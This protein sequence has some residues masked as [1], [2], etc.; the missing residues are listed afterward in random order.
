[1]LFD[2]LDYL[3][4]TGIEGGED[5][6]I[7]EV[8]DTVV[9][10]TETDVVNEPQVEQEVNEEQP[11][12]E[13]EIDGEKYT[14]DQIKEWKLGNMRQSDYSRKTQEVS[15]MRKEAEEAIEVYNY[16]KSNPQLVNALLQ[17]EDINKNDADFVK[18]KTDPTIKEIQDLKQKYYMIEI[19]KELAD[20]TSKDKDVNDVELL[21]IANQQNCDVKTAYTIWKG[22]N[23]DK[24]IEKKIKET[25]S[26]L[27]KEIQSNRGVTKTLITGA[28][29]EV[30]DGNYG[31]SDIELAYAKK[32][33]MTPEEYAKYKHN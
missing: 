17:N 26:G 7:G 5:S 3:V 27:A 12:K 21:Q 32:L 28:D 9:D 14:L 4:A 10:N 30:P 31:L 19:E 2:Y 23:F 11:I 8:A 29:K 24:L 18:Q 25:K 16:L 6:G 1:M 22:M 15:R 20:I 33:E 13:Y